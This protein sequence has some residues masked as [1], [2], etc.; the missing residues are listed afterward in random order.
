MSHDADLLWRVN[1]EYRNRLS[2][3]MVYVDLLEQMILTHNHGNNMGEIQAILR[4]V[5]DEVAYMK[6]EHRRWRYQFYYES[7]ETKKIV[8]SDSA[9]H[10]ALARFS[11]MRSQ[12]E[13]R[14]AELQMQLFMLQRPDP[15]LTQVPNGDLWQLTQFAMRQLSQFE[16]YMRDLNHLT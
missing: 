9:I 8:R 12:H 15:R 2:Q 11:R 7:A 3:V 10:Q 14:L 1:H 4:H 16:D 13:R 5:Y 6:E